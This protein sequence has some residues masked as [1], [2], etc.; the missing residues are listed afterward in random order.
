MDVNYCEV[1]VSSKT[2]YHAFY[3]VLKNTEAV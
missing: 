1:V 3:N 2:N